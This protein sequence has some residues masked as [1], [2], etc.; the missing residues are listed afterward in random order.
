MGVADV[1]RLHNLVDL[2]LKSQ[3]FG[4]VNF[5]GLH[6][7]LHGILTHIGLK[8]DGKSLKEVRNGASLERPSDKEEIIKTSK[9]VPIESGESAR[10]DKTSGSEEEERPE[11]EDKEVFEGDHDQISSLHEREQ[12]EQHDSK[13]DEEISKDQD[14]ESLRSKQRHLEN[15]ISNLED[16]LKLL[17]ELPSNKAIIQ[18]AQQTDS[19]DTDNRNKESTLSGVWQFMKINSRLQAAE[20][21]IDRV[22]S[23]LNEFLGGGKTLGEM[24]G[25]IQDLSKEL[26]NLKNQLNE[27]TPKDMENV[28][29]NLVKKEDLRE[30]VKWP[31]LEEALQIQKDKNKK[32]KSGGNVD[33]MD[34]EKERKMSGGSYEGRPQTSPA[35][36]TQDPLSD[37]PK[38][39]MLSEFTQVSSNELPEDQDTTHPSPEVVECLRRIG[40]LSDEHDKVEKQ[41][42]EMNK[43]LSNKMDKRDF[44]IPQDLQDKLDALQKGLDSLM[45]NGAS[46]SGG[47]EVKDVAYDNK[48]KIDAIRRELAAMARQAKQ[49]YI[50]RPPNVPAI[51]NEALDAIRNKLS[52]LQDKQVKQDTNA[53][54]TDQKIAELMEDLNLKKEH[55]DNLYK[56]IQDLQDNKADKDNVAMEMDH[57]ADKSALQNMVNT[58]TFD[59]SFNML[60]E[61]LKE[62]LQK[63][64]EYMNEELALKQALK[65]LSCDMKE[66]MDN[67]ALKALQNYLEKRIADVQ[68]S[69]TMIAREANVDLTGAAGLRRPLPIDFHCISCN[70]PVEVKY[71]SDVQPSLPKADSMHLKR[72]KGPYISYEMDQVRHYQRPMY[73]PDKLT[74][75]DLV[76]SRPCGGSHTVMTQPIRK[77][78]RLHNSQ[79]SHVLNGSSREEPPVTYPRWT[80]EVSIIDFVKGSDGHVYKGRYKA[81]P[82]ISRKHKH[83]PS[84]SDLPPLDKDSTPPLT[85]P[86][87]SS[88]PELSRHL[89]E[90]SSPDEREQVNKN[91][92]NQEHIRTTPP[93]SKSVS[94]NTRIKRILSQRSPDQDLERVPSPSP[95]TARENEH[96]HRMSRE[97]FL[98]KQQ[99]E[100]AEDRLF[101]PRKHQSELRTTLSEIEHTEDSL[102]KGGYVTRLYSPQIQKETRP[103][104]SGGKEVVA[105]AID[106]AKGRMSVDSVDDIIS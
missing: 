59:S 93:L 28:L 87:W 37:V 47:K 29:K 27:K 61:G 43:I 31:A 39:A 101:S 16:K 8:Y 5:K 96:Q 83:T 82:P 67:E 81:I 103:S 51:D 56:Y 41:V 17:D 102:N 60:D 52:E 95:P 63:M 6:E 106:L 23:L 49:S 70:R 77:P 35:S 62:A 74:S 99:Q 26:Q 18:E 64:D 65:Q 38:T 9:G 13:T 25:N 2:S 50:E 14:V 69:R 73:R 84:E 94:P 22:M 53:G 86:K 88:E 44:N 58:T 42:N 21:G 57:K 10:G 24:S 32:V 79:L 89:N 33:I 54:N 45:Q 97:E 72:S 36:P 66:K 91:R 20:E 71:N 90:S 30:Y 34:V 40:E 19:S 105:S 68:K 78:V 7:L 11:D 1:E 12:L 100:M 104:K 92:D 48:E 4:I 76:T 80:R 15:K 85:R 3:E 46:V 98:A 55:I 75:G